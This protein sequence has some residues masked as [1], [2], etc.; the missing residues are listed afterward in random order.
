MVNLCTPKYKRG[1]VDSEILEKV[2]QGN[3]SR[4]VRFL[5]SDMH[6]GS[7]DDNITCFN[8]GKPCHKVSKC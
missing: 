6:D 5:C 8:E 4:F 1:L 2:E 3:D 7:Q